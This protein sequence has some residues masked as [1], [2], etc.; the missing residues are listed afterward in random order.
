M[1]MTTTVTK[2]SRNA[3][4]VTRNAGELNEDNGVMASG[5]TTSAGRWQGA[6]VLVLWLPNGPRSGSNNETWNLDQCLPNEGYGRL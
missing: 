1:K 4:V 6:R 2:S 5:Q 3:T